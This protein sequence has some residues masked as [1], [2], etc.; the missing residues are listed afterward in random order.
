MEKYILP[1]KEMNLATNKHLVLDA[2]VHKALKEKRKGAGLT[3]REIGNS[4][5]RGV[6][7]RP[8][9]SE[10]IGKK[11]IEKGMVTPEEFTDLMTEVVSETTTL[12]NPYAELVEITPNRTLLSGNWESRELFV[13]RDGSF[14][15]LEGWVRNGEYAQVKSHY[16]NQSELIFVLSGEIEIRTDIGKHKLEA[17]ESVLIP[18]KVMHSTTPLT[19]NAR[20]LITNVPSWS[21]FRQ[22]DSPAERVDRIDKGIS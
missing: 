17:L 15:L 22:P 20:I 5:L 12:A 16:H 10:I 8:F 19:S 18:S 11:L 1:V 4:I 9:R 7:S 6:L 13:A 2:D 14:E 21:E 3:I